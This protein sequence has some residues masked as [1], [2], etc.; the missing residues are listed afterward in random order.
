MGVGPDIYY[1]NISELEWPPCRK[2]PPAIIIS[3]QAQN[4]LETPRLFFRKRI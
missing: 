2:T 4:Y 3:T 1:G